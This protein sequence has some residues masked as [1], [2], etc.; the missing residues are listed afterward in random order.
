MIDRAHL[1]IVQAFDTHGSLTAAAKTLNLTQSA[2]SH[3][4]KQAGAA[5][6]HGNLAARMGAIFA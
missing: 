3:T 4:M 5:V 1:E 2:L 6:K